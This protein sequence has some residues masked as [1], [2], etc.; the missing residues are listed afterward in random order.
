MPITVYILYE[1]S[2]WNQPFIDEMSRRGMDC[3]LWD[4]K[5][6]HI[7]LDSPPPLAPGPAVVFN[8][9]SPSSYWRS[10]PQALHVATEMLR[11][12]D[13]HKVPVVSGERPL[14][15][16]A[17]KGLQHL[18]CRRHGVPAPP[19]RLCTADTLELALRER[20][21]ARAQ[22]GEEEEEA[23]GARLPP[24]PHLLKPNCGGSGSDIT[25]AADKRVRSPD[26]LVLVQDYVESPSDTLVRMEFVG[27][28]LL[29]ALEVRTSREDFNNCP[30]DHCTVEHCP[31]GAGAAG[32]GKFRRLAGFPNDAP[33]RE[34]V[35]RLRR[36]IDTNGLDIAGV[37]AI[38]D[39]G[40]S[41]WVIDI[42]C[43]NTNYNRAIERAC[44]PG[45]SG[46]ERVVDLLARRAGGLRS[47]RTSGSPPGSAPPPRG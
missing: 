3:V 5:T 47:P 34:L 15:L 43:V 38:C 27:G 13:A 42:N 20:G 37:E 22:A 18:E 33:Q 6:A 32:G 35:Q 41:W 46:V 2:A 31:I 1:N 19:T 12:L 17:S 45:G 16:E 30:S 7:D 40:G 29:Y 14:R 21:A 10:S 8:R 11:W 24:P 26:H 4:L 25:L 39:A 36:L 44:A 23:G 9:F 28:E